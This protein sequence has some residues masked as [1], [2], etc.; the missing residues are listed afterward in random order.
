MVS[1][2][3]PVYNSAKYLQQCVQSLTEQTYSDLQIVLID[4]GSTDESWAIMRELASSDKRIEVY[5]QPNMGVAAT[6]NHLLDKIRGDF[7]LFVDSD[8]WIDNN[9]IEILLNKQQEG[10]YDI[11]GFQMKGT[12]VADENQY[13][14]EQIIKLF[15][16]HIVFTGSLCNKFVK[17]HLYDNLKLDENV[18]YG[19][20]ALLMW[21]V[22]QKINKV[23]TIKK[24]LYH[25]RINQQSI[26]H[27]H[28]NGRKCTKIYY[29]LFLISFRRNSEQNEKVL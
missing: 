1:I 11:V 18:A 23:A 22:I 12:L 29:I 16:E 21:Q 13:N 15:L 5:S 14:Q 7:V 19:E 3:V 17:S 4:D 27:Q 20:D 8:D 25:Y 10:D 6:R 28:F 2:L 9:T 26:S 24:Q